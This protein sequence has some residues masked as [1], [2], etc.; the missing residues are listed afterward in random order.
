MKNRLIVCL[1][2]MM[3]ALSVEA[4]LRVGLKVGISTTDIQGEDLSIL[5]PG[6]G[7]RFRLALEEAKYGIHGGLVIRWKKNKFILQ[8]EINFNSSTA[9]YQ[10]EDLQN[11]SNSGIKSEKYQNLDI[12]LL[13]GAKFGP[14]RLQAGPVGHVFINSVSDLSSV[15]GFKDRYESLTFGWQAGL[16]LDL[17]KFMLDLRYEGNFTKYG[18]H[19]TFFGNDYNFDDRPARFLFSFGYL[20]GK[21]DKDR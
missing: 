16:G 6:G 1:I 10:F 20:F 13:L 4:Q 2:L 7:Q 12:P 8:P 3:G 18:D 15:D 11:P 14:L 5:E 9:E 17:W 21:Q 19:I